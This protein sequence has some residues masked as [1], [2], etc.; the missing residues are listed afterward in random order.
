MERKLP[1][2]SLEKLLLKDHKAMNENLLL[3]LYVIVL[4]T[5]VSTIMVVTIR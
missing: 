1:L 2:Y 4:L 5:T 3:L